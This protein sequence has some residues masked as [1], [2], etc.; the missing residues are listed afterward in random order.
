MTI[1]RGTDN[2]AMYTGRARVYF[3][4]YELAKALEGTIPTLDSNFFKK[5]RTSIPR[6]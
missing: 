3:A 2:R 1:P 4:A 5:K 6:H